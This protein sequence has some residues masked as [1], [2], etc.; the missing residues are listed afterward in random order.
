MFDIKSKISRRLKTLRAH[1]GWTF[2]ETAAR[3]SSSSGTKVI[4]SRY[5]NWELGINTPP[6]DLLISLGTLFDK[7]APYIAGLTDDDGTMPETREYMIPPTTAVPSP[8]GVIDLGDSALAFHVD[9]LDEVSLDRERILSVMAPD[10]SMSG[11]IEEG[12]RALI[13]LRE[14]TVTRDDM[15]A[16]MVNG[17]LWLRWIRQTIDGAYVIQAEQR[18]RYPDTPLTAEKLESLHILGRIRLITHLR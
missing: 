7:P 9:F 6:L 1:K 16:I 15:F 11:V 13:D 17:R 12:D 5:G 18:D 8:N 10:S 14:T 4:P 2:N 3:L